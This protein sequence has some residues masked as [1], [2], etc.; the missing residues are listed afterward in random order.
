MSLAPTGNP[1]SPYAVTSW[2]PAPGDKV[3]GFA[4]D[5]SAVYL[6]IGGSSVR[7]VNPTTGATIWSKSVSRRRRCQSS[8]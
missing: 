6:G 8:S 1:A 5:S 3:R 7:A 2:N 4:V